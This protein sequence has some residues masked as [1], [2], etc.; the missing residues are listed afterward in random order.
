MSLTV[1]QPRGCVLGLL[2]TSHCKMIFLLVVL[3]FH[4]LK[5]W[6]LLLRKVSQVN[7]RDGRIVCEVDV[8]PQ[9]VVSSYLV[10]SV[11]LSELLVRSEGLGVY[12]LFLEGFLVL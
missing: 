6:L 11:L 3:H 10:Q 4:G 1:V 5:H 8:I 2:F 7:L 9:V 12:I